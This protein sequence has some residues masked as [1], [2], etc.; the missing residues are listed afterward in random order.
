MPQLVPFADSDNAILYIKNTFIEVPHKPA[1][2]RPER[3]A[4]SLPPHFRLDEASDLHHKHRIHLPPD[5]DVTTDASTE[6]DSETDTLSTSPASCSDSSPASWSEISHSSSRTPLSAKAKAWTPGSFQ[7]PE[8][9][10][11]VCMPVQ[12]AVQV[13]N[14]SMYNA[15]FY[16]PL[17]F[18]F[19]QSAA[20]IVSFTAKQAQMK[21]A[22]ARVDLHNVPE[23]GWEMDVYV[24]DESVVYRVL[25]QIMQSL[26][27][28]AQVSSCTYITSYRRRPFSMSPDGLSFSAEF[29]A[30]R[31]EAEACWLYYEKGFC[32]GQ[33]GRA[34][35]P[36]TLPISVQILIDD[37][38][39]D[40]T[41]PQQRSPRSEC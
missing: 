19:A 39:G 14:S 23:G 21:A 40:Q 18:E 26:L 9:G 27:K 10:A 20:K 5:S 33:C 28:G 6:A 29:A 12:Q 7:T 1:V 30:M 2:Q 25:R 3:R 15:S 36:C 4:S 37:T 32:R 41:L 34:H 31:D 11:L 16:D 38:V 24:H 8:L 13:F 17:P 22:V 35:P